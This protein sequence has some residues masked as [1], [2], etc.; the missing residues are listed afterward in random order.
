[1]FHNIPYANR[2]WGNTQTRRGPSIARLPSDFAL[3][4]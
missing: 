1:M 3:H 4:A 2:A